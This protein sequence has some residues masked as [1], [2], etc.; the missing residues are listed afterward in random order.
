AAEGRAILVS[1]HLMSEL[2]DTADHLIV[3]GRAALMLDQA[4]GMESRRIQ[5]RI[6]RVRD[7]V[8]GVSDGRPA[9]ELA[10]RVADMT[11]VPLRHSVLRA[12]C[13]YL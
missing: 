4:A 2:E 5:E 6:V 12:S 7:A 11:G 9:A 3:A 13:C 1:S 10:E 8:T